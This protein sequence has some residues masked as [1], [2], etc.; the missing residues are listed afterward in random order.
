MAELTRSA[1]NTAG[2]KQLSRFVARW[3]LVARGRS[4]LFR[5]TALKPFVAFCV[6][7]RRANR[8]S[9]GATVIDSSDKTT[10]ADK[11][12]VDLRERAWLA[13]HRRGETGA[14]TELL[15]AYRRPVYNYLF[16]CG[17]DTATR[18]DLF[19]DIFL[20]IHLNAASYEPARPLRPWVFTIAANTVRNHLRDR[21]KRDEVLAHAMPEQ[22]AHPAPGTQRRAE[23]RE[24]LSWLAEAI[25][26]LPLEQRE[27]LVMV[28]IEGMAL[29]EVAEAL[30]T[31]VNS[32]KTR[33]RRARLKLLE[34]QNHAHAETTPLSGGSRS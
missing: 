27:V 6:Q 31:P 13:R 7:C 29:S 23:Q 10:K 30:Q 25:G 21:G 24:T 34:K 32:V 11:P 19:Q 5:S 9:A 8:S 3:V 12:V 16:R 18:D 4:C 20:K 22:A 26:T 2:P 33:L 28:S 1:T 15:S 14:F 17:L